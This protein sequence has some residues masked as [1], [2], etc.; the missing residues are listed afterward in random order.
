MKKTDIECQVKCIRDFAKGKKIQVIA[1]NQLVYIVTPTKEFRILKKKECFLG[2]NNQIITTKGSFLTSG[3]KTLIK[4]CLL[5]RDYKKDM[6]VSKQFNQLKPKIEGT[7]ISF[8]NIYN[9][10]KVLTITGKRLEKFG[11]IDNLMF[12]YL[13]STKHLLVWDVLDGALLGWLLP[14]R[15]DRW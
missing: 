1:N 10:F 12:S 15:T 2:I 13:D 9:N 4:E 6:R 11:K 3:R 5:D 8:I 7:K 14:N